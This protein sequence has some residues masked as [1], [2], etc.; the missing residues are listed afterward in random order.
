MKKAVLS[1]FV[2]AA[3]AGSAFAQEPVRLDLRIVRQSGFVP[4]TVTDVD[5]N[6]SYTATAGEVIRFEVQ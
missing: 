2:V 6:S 1:A 3:C 5:A 4:A